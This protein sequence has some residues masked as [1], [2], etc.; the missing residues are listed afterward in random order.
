MLLQR[1]E[2]RN[3]ADE[4]CFP[5]PTCPRSGRRPVVR[6]KQAYLSLPRD[7]PTYSKIRGQTGADENHQHLAC[8]GGN[9]YGLIKSS[10]WLGN[11]PATPRAAQ[12][13]APLGAAAAQPV[14]H[15]EY[16]AVLNL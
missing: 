15:L 16:S 4:E 12:Y 5:F 10:R 7:E 1:L 13:N 9:R 8:N 14:A 3:A 11:I 6:L 2:R